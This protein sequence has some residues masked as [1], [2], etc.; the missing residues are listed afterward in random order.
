VQECA[1]AKFVVFPDGRTTKGAVRRPFGL[2]EACRSGLAAR[3]RTVVSVPVRK[4]TSF[5]GAIMIFRQEV[6]PFTDNEI[7]VLQNFARQAVIAME[8]P[9]PLGE[10]RQRADEVAGWDRELEARVAA[11]VEELGRLGRM[12]RFLAP[13]T[14]RVDRLAE[15]RKDPRKP[16]PRNSRRVL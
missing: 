3:K 7:D 15:G 9:R 6:R 14:R 13:A 8:N 2:A 10:L 4:E 1:V 12:K 11:Q 5:L 16:S